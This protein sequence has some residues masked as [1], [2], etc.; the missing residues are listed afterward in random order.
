MVISFLNP[1][2]KI[3]LFGIIFLLANIIGLFLIFKSGENYLEDPSLVVHNRKTL[4]FGKIVVGFSMMFISLM[5]IGE[6]PIISSLLYII[7]LLGPLYFPLAL[8]IDVLAY[9]VLHAKEW[10][11]QDLIIA[12]NFV[13]SPSITLT[14]G[15]YVYIRSKKPMIKAKTSWVNGFVLGY[16]TMAIRRVTSVRIPETY[17]GTDI[18]LQGEKWEVRRTPR[19]TPYVYDPGSRSNPHI[20]ITGSSGVGKTTTTIYIVSQLLKKGYPVIVFDP[21]GDISMTAIIRGWHEEKNGERKKVLI[22]DVDRLGVD[23]LQ[24]VA[25]EGWIEKVIDLVN[26]M[27]VVEEVGANQKYLILSSAKEVEKEQTYKALLERVRKHVDAFLE[28][29]GKRPG[30]GPHIRD[31]YVSI[32]NKLE[33]LSTIFREGSRFRMVMLNPEKWPEDV[34][35]IIL[36][37]SKIRDRYSRAVTM[38]LLLRKLELMLRERGPLAF[39]MK[40]IF[41]VVDEAHELSRAQ[42]WREDVTASILEDMAREAR[43]HGAGLI[44]VTQRLADIPDGI[45]MNT[46]LWLCLKTDSP[47]DIHILKT[48]MPVGRLPE[49]VTSMPE[50]YALVVEAMPQRLERMQSIS[51]KPM[52]I[53]EGYIIKLER[54]MVEIKES[55]EGAI[56]RLKDASEKAKKDSEKIIEDIIIKPVKNELNYDENDPVGRAVL[57]TYIKLG[58]DDR[59]KLKN[60]PREV[61]EKFIEKMDEDLNKLPQELQQLF[62][63]HGLLCDKEGR[64]VESLTGRIF[65]K[66]YREVIRSKVIGNK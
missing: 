50:G 45:R 51:S 14:I 62:S 29:N 31:A 25:G 49:I 66:T 40:K 65:K 17:L 30:Y 44:L 53:E 54:R 58:K 43:S 22:V 23:P 59:E 46:G 55:V 10:C 20:C 64:I 60:I 2:L 28:K 6:L 37:L 34:A 52:A 9:I 7:N 13:N 16:V 63:K 32:R 57:L 1:L 39:L 24:E 15:C 35:G 21:K 18:I 56:Q 36:D 11:N 33:V 48:V 5:P 27:S 19:E 8:V 38:E 42:R 26:A 61:V 12:L 3:G 47:H 41:I 4:W